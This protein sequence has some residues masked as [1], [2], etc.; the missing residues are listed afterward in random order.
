MAMHPFNG[1]PVTELY[2]RWYY[3]TA[4]GYR[5]GGEK[6]VAF[7]K[8]AGDITWFN[9][10]LNCGAGGSTTT[11]T[12]H[13]QIIHGNSAQCRS[14]NVNPI[15]LE[16]GRWYFFEVHVRLNSS[17]V[18]GDGLIEMW[19]NDCG[20]SG[21]CTGSPTLRTRMENVSFNRNQSGCLTTPCRVEVLWFENWANPP[22]TGTNKYD[23]IVA[24]RT[25]PIGFMP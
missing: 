9:V 19:I 21:Q 24:S 25:G 18:V 3:Y 13:I 2:A 17:G 10:Q 23:Q 12:P 1:G 4:P 14:P 22:S 20:T 16:S 11:A 6:N 7:T 5:W 8:E 15:S